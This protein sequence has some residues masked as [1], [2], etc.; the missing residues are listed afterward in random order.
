MS[1]LSGAPIYLIDSLA[2]QTADSHLERAVN[3]Q[4]REDNGEEEEF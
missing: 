2:L 3:L 1:E 4:P